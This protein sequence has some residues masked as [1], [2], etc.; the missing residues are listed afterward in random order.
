MTKKQKEAEEIK[1]AHVADIEKNL[2]YAIRN[3][4]LLKNAAS[5]ALA[6]CKQRKTI[7][8]AKEEIEASL[9]GHLDLA[10][11][12]RYSLAEVNKILVFNDI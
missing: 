1:S 10:D 5:C 3:L 12:V 11:N 7:L 8:N 2:E 4:E 9:K 6:A